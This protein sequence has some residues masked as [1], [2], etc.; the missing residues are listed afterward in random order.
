MATVSRST[1]APP[2]DQ[3]GG[4]GRPP[5]CLGVKIVGEL[6]AGWAIDAGLARTT[7]AIVLFL[8]RY[9]ADVGL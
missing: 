1:Y 9:N 5:G 6:R 7:L 2:T 3:S 4:R 8:T